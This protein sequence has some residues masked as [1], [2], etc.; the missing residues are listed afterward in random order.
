[1]RRV[2]AGGVEVALDRVERD[3]HRDG[4]VGQLGPAEVAGEIRGKHIVGALRRLPVE[5]ELAMP[6]PDRMAV[7]REE[8]RIKSLP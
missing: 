3:L 8:A 1:M 5:L 6:M 4:S 7:R 2:E